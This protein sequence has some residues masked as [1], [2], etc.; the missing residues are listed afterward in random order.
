MKKLIIYF[1]PIVMIFVSSC[2][3]DS[4]GTVTDPFGTGN[5]GGNTGGTG[6]VT[7]TI[8]TTNG[9]QG[10]IVF[11]ASPS[12]AVKIT[13]VT[14]NLAA[15]NFTDVL[16]GDGTTVYNANEAVGLEEYTGVESGQQW[17][18]QF[19]GTTSADNKAFNVT[20]NFTIP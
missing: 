16:T 15:Q 6:N 17:T 20:S 3:N 1:I 2:S 13:K 8:G 4:G 10:G 14:L 5:N 9:Q 18:F 7:F 12:V 19:E 11:T